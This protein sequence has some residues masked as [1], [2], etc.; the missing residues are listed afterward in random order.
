MI[1]VRHVRHA[2]DAYGAI[3]LTIAMLTFA[4]TCAGIDIAMANAVG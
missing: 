3:S 2:Y 4:L 1:E